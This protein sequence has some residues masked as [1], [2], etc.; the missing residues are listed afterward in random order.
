MKNFLILGLVALL[1]FAVSA[2]L[3]LWLNSSKEGEAD[4]KEPKKTAKE[5]T[6]DKDKDKDD[7]LRPAIK[8]TPSLGTDEGGRLA[9]QLR[10]QL[11]IVKERE[12]K[13]DRRQA[14]I[15]LLLQDVRSEREVIENLRKQV[16]VE[17]KMVAEKMT[18]VEGRFT[19]L[20]RE[21]EQNAKKID[22]AQ[23]RVLDITQAE[24]KNISKMAT[25]YDSMPAENA[26]KIMQQMADSGK[27]E[28]A[29]KLLSQMKETKAAKVLAEISD[30]ALAAQMLEK[31]RGVKRTTLPI[32]PGS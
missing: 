27:M 17:M 14:H 20:D 28:T 21:R 26:A 9:A 8:P 1:L 18:E 4:K 23:K 32:G 25:M 12:A 30:P 11:A 13:L 15:E 5:T 22:E 19:Q 7:E 2:A 31:M 6:K 3:S 24:D 29:V 10:E 16:A